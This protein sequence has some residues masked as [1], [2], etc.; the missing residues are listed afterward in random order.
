MKNKKNKLNIL[1]WGTF[2]KTKPRNRILQN[3]LSQVGCILQYC[4]ANIWMGENDKSQ[5]KK[6]SQWGNILF[7]YM[8]EYPKLIAKFCKIDKTDFILVGYLGHIDVLILWPFAKIKGVPIVWD[9]FISLYNTVVEDRKLVSKYNPLSWLLYIFEWTACRAADV[10]VL[11][12]RAHAN[13]FR[14]RYK[15]DQN[16]VAHTYVGAE[17]LFF[18]QQIIR[19]RKLKQQHKQ[20]NVLFYGT[21]IPLH[22]ITTILSAAKLIDN[23][24]VNWTLIGTGQEA[25]KYKLEIEQCSNVSWN[26]W[27]E[28]ESLIEK[29]NEA[30]VCLGIFGST[31]KSDMVIPNKVFQILA[32]NKPLITR[33]SPAIKELLSGEEPGV[34]L[35]PPNN[36]DELIRAVITAMNEREKLSS[37][38]LHHEVNEQF[39]HK[40]IGEKLISSLKKAKICDIEMQ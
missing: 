8:K 34:W 39:T 38:N 35:I 37:L 9:A 25:E 7:S 31:I 36:A 40:A 32:A 23:K 2:D 4:H 3:G 5:L 19:K 10:V 6:V 21:F 26:K 1:V 18:D 24:L 14:S 20:F 13:Y 12:T 17:E 30:D 33:S 16:K 29:I 22:G 15:L 28:Y 27:V 11:D